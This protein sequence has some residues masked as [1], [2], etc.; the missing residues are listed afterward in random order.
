[1]NQRAKKVA[2]LAFAIWI[3]ISLV[4][5]IVS[6]IVL[7]VSENKTWTSVAEP[8]FSNNAE[9]SEEI[10]EILN[11]KYLD[12]KSV[13]EEDGRPVCFKVLTQKGEF[14][15]TL[16]MEQISIEPDEFIV[17][18]HLIETTKPDFVS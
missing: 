11:F 18:K 16:W 5:G 15:I 13:S 6:V 8:Y 12:M 9:I 10:G 7:M 2:G 4:V 14:Y 3:L 17:S 1:M